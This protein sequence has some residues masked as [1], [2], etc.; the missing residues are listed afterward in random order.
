MPR[1]ISILL[2]SLFLFWS[3]Q[4]MAQSTTTDSLQALL[5]NSKD[6]TRVNL[7]N[8]LSS[9]YWYTDPARTI[10]YAS[11]AIELGKKLDFKKGITT[12]YN[13]TG[14]GYY[15]Q[16]KYKQALEWY[17]KALAMHRESGNFRGEGFVLSNIGL[18]Y[19]KQGDT[20]YRRGSLP[21]NLKDLG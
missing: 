13:N 7:L 11:E 9:A 12:A 16:N 10:V 19:W 5:K 4:N 6:T 20:A 14:V 1:S 2:V 18:I 17:N 3:V 15:Q 8:Q 21:A